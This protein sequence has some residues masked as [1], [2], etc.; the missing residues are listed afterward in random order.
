[1]MI[2]CQGWIAPVIAACLLMGCSTTPPVPV[3]RG[4]KWVSAYRVLTAI[5]KIAVESQGRG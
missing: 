5:L 2:A 1:M 4:E 3:M